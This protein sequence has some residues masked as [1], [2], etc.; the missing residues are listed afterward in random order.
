[1]SDTKLEPLVVE[2]T[3]V[4]MFCNELKTHAASAGSPEK[5]GEAAWRESEP[6]VREAYRARATQILDALAEDGVSVRASKKST[7]ALLRIVTVPAHAAYTI[8]GVEL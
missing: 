1:M 3:A 4:H 2:L 5:D 6:A 8:P 7:A